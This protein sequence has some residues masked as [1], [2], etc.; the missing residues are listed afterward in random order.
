MWLSAR[1]EGELLPQLLVC[2]HV[3][4]CRCG[5][6]LATVAGLSAC[7]LEACRLV[8]LADCCRLV[9]VCRREKNNMVVAVAVAM[10]VA[11][12]CG[13]VSV[14]RQYKKR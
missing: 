14:C 7:H 8:E 6:H 3:E 1:V 2:L 4:A 11:D 9:T 12:R 10:T 5:V 13:F